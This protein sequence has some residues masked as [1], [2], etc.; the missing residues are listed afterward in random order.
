MLGPSSKVAGHWEWGCSWH[1]SLNHCR[2][3]KELIFSVF[4]GW[5]WKKR[6][7]NGIFG[8]DDA[9][10]DSIQWCKWRNF[11]W[12]RAH[13]EQRPLRSHGKGR[14][15]VP[16]R[17]VALTVEQAGRHRRS[18]ALW[19]WRLPCLTT[20]SGPGAVATRIQG[21]HGTCPRTL[22]FVYVLNADTVHEGTPFSNFPI[23]A[24]LHVFFGNFF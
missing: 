2:R 6:L 7:A 16:P 5:G 3:I 12:T 19:Q 10:L 13:C 22:E 21:R 18:I 15:A 1:G 4:G 24:P 11:T 9:I 14:L 23:F 20:A 8:V 17:G